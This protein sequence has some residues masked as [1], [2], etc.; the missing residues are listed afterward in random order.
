[1]AGAA[2]AELFERHIATPAAI[3]LA[4]VAALGGLRHVEAS[5]ADEVRAAAAD[6]GL[7]EIRTDRHE[8]VALHRA[9]FARVAEQL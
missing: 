6:P 9:L 3:D 4:E 2:A 1:V 8:N 5:T 7:I